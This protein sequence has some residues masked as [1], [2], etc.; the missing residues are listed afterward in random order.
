MFGMQ[1]VLAAGFTHREGAHV[2]VDVLYNLFP[3]RVKAG[4]GIFTSIFF[5][6]FVIALFG[7]CWIFAADSMMVMEVSFTEWAIQ[8]W[9]VK[10]TMVI[11]AV[12]LFLDGI[13]K[14]I[15]D[16]YILAGKEI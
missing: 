9:P 3:E 1:Y 6:I 13:I 2:H 8:Y 15:K 7:T 16:F 10:I 11:G 14:L 4:I 12:L 5:F